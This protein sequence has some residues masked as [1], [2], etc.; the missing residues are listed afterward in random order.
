MDTVTATTYS[1]VAPSPD[2]VRLLTRVR[3]KRGVYLQVHFAWVEGVLPDI[4]YKGCIQKLR[5]LDGSETNRTRFDCLFIG[6]ELQSWNCLL[7]TSPSPR[8]RG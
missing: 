7:Y 5:E 4:A 1:S 8:D 2:Q 6:H 3:S